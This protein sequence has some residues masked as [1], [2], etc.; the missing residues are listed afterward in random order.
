[1]DRVDELPPLGD[2]HRRALP[3]RSNVEQRHRQRVTRLG[4]AN[5]DGTRRAV[6]PSEIKLLERVLFAL[7]LSGEAVPRLDFN[8]GAGID[9]DDGLTSGGK[10]PHVL[11]TTDLH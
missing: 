11:V 9:G 4:A 10:G 5:G 6:H 2:A 7:Y 3:V 8:D 1:M